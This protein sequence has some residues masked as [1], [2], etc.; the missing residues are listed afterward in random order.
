MNSLSYNEGASR[1]TA[2]DILDMVWRKAPLL[3]RVGGLA[4]PEREQVRHPPDVR[5]R[6]VRRFC[7]LMHERQNVYDPAILRT[8]ADEMQLHY[9]SVVHMTRDHRQR[10]LRGPRR[11]EVTA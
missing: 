8:I 10:V 7:D 11:K 9:Q 4:I 6:V 5:E 2:A 1:G 3:M